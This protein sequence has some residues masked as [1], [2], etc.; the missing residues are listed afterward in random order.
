MPVRRALVLAVVLFCATLAVAQPQNARERAR[1]AYTS[2]LEYMRVERFADAA[3]SFE[4]ATSTDPSFELAHYMLGRAYLALKDYYAA[5]DALTTARD[6]YVADATR[7]FQDRAEGQRYRRTRIGELDDLLSQ[8]RSLPRQTPEIQ[9]QIRQLE[10]HRRQL[11]DRDR[12]VDADAGVPAFVLLSLGS[13]HFRAGNFGLAEQAWRD[14]VAADPGSGEA[15][16]NLAVVLL[17]TGRY[18][19]AEQSVRNAEKAGRRV[20]QA[21]KDEIKKRRKSSPR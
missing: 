19:E 15:H 16:N 6:L 1:P 4:S 8:L 11:E 17:E 13:A 3:A 9:G 10:E 2:G 5:V 20:P 18:D 21:L 14:A 12:H 7:R